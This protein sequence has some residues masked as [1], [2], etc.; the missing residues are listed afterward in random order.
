MGLVFE[1]AHVAP[2]RAWLPQVSRLW[3][4]GLG[5]AALCVGPCP[6][7]ESG[8]FKLTRGLLERENGA[9]R[10]IRVLHFGDSHLVSGPQAGFIAGVLKQ[11][12][13]DG[14]PG[15]GLPGSLPRYQVRHGLTSGN[16]SG[17][18]RLTP[19]P[20]SPVDD[21]GLVCGALE[22]DQEG[23]EAWIS[24]MAQEFRIALLAQPGG[25]RV[26]VLLDGRPVG[27]VDLAAAE[28]V[29]QV[30]AHSV[31]GPARIH[32][33][34]FRTLGKGKVR[35][36]GVTLE[37]SGGGVVYSPLGLLGARAGLLLRWKEETFARLIAYEEPDLIILS[38]GTNE[39]GDR[40]FDD[41][42]YGAQF[43]RLLD[44]IRRAVPDAAVW[45]IGPPDRATRRGDGWQSLATLENVV[46]YEKTAARRAGAAF[47]DLRQAMGGA[48]VIHRWAA[49]RPALAQDD[50]IHYTPE[51]Y[52][53]LASLTLERFFEMVD[54]VRRSPAFTQYLRDEGAASEL[55]A[56]TRGDGLRPGRL[57]TL[58]ELAG[59][60]AEV[61]EPA[62]SVAENNAL[63]YFENERGVLVI[64]N[65]PAVRPKEGSSG[66]SPR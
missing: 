57:P 17:W 41:S 19:R 60:A 13:G 10:K 45:I 54:E 5:V 43:Q 50:H 62:A 32:R 34:S 37:K 46:T 51:G 48:G 39:A 7:A 49:L 28:P 14:G 1:T 31:E 23:Q 24:G 35:L 63:V 56:L 18:R 44:R 22:T 4:A 61:P 27:E 65:D 66:A 3:L 6:A 53:K 47:F 8:L 11:A 12:F 59:V 52:G 38:F 20:D 25:G 40:P 64:T 36:L 42:G 29:A 26:S 2:Q 33:L 9:P 15:L 21:L 58:Q 16:S 55:L 30:F